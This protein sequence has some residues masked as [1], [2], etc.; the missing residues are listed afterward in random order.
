MA[1]RDDGDVMMNDECSVREAITP[2]HSMMYLAIASVDLNVQTVD[3]GRD[4]RC[5]ISGSGFM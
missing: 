5:A 1:C 4:Y 2:R 3:S